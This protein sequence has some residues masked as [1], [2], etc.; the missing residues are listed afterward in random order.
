[1]IICFIT[2]GSDQHLFSSIEMFHESLHEFE[3]FI[4][5]IKLLFRTC[6]ICK[7]TALQCT[8]ISTFASCSID[9]M[10]PVMRKPVFGGFRPGQTQTSLCTVTEDRKGTEI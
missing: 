6:N 7:S 8:P 2:F 3:N 1:M 10:R 5:L 4:Q 9:G